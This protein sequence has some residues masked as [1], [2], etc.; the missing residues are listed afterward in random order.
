MTVRSDEQNI[1]AARNR[2]IAT[3]KA[4]VERLKH[5]KLLM[6]DLCEGQDNAVEEIERRAKIEVLEE[7]WDGRGWPLTHEAGYEVACDVYDEI[8]QL[9]LKQEGE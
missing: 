3:L 8:K 5:E 7:V 9:K 4:E 6:R 2:E 1:I